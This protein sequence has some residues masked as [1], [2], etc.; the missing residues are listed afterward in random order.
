MAPLSTVAERSAQSGASE[1]T[2]QRADKVAKADP[3]LAKQVAHGGFATG[4][5]RKGGRRE[6]QRRNPVMVSENAPPSCLPRTPGCG[7]ESRSRVTRRSKIEDNSQMAA[8]FEAD[9]R[10][11]AAMA[12]IKRLKG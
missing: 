1:R 7:S 3:E 8:I 12:E 11:A 6:N 4:S 9:D 10:L 2:Q 5:S